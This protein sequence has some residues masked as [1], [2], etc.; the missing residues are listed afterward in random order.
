MRGPI[1]MR[2]AVA[3][4]INRIAVEEV[5]LDPPQPGEVLVRMMAAGVCHS[6]LH[7]LQGEMRATPPIVLGHEG[8]GV[9]EAVGSAI[10]HVRP[11]DRVLVN[12][13]PACR[14]CGPCSRGM[15]SQCSRLYATTY[16]ALLPDGTTRLHA[17]DGSPLKQYLS[18]ATFAQFAVLD[19]SG[20]IPLPDDVPFE[21]AALIGCAVVTG[22][23]AVFNTA[24]AK[25]G[26]S[27]AVIGCGGVGLSALL[28]CVHVGC[29]PL[30][31][32][33][34]HAEKLEYA[35]TLGATHTLLVEP[36]MKVPSAVRKLLGRAP[37]YAFDSVGATS[38]I[39][40]ALD[41]VDVGGSAVVMGLH[42][43]HKPAPINPVSLVYQNKRLLGSFFGEADPLVDLPAL[44]ELQRSGRL[45]VERLITDRYTLD[46]APQALADLNAGRIRGRGVILF[47]D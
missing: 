9:I 18:S 29:T 8:A 28:G 16:Q 22:A 15:P 43:V 39:V 10:T 33:D 37:M 40:D 11:G 27:A 31:A 32:I 14:E 19:G 24:Q 23:G 26:Q 42:G 3:H 36:G 20:V 2:A 6:D 44:L 46:Q 5:T 41:M 4:E 30:L 7:T 35:R 47:D 45:P 21:V 1:T 38:T 17:A 25:A 34:T 13:I 12:W